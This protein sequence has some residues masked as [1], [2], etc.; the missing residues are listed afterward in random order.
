MDTV[1][2]RARDPGADES[3]GPLNTWHDVATGVWAD[4]RYLSGVE[5]LRA[6]GEVSVVRASIRIRVDASITSAMRAVDE[7][8]GTVFEI[9]AVLPDK[10]SRAYTHLVAEVVK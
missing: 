6:G 2:F 9:K 4:I 10:L 7:A 3:G 5:T 1:T 8:D